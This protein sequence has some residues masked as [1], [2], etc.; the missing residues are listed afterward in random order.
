MKVTL[1]HPTAMT[2]NWKQ[3]LRDVRCFVVCAPIFISIN[4]LSLLLCSSHPIWYF[5]PVANESVVLAKYAYA[6][7]IMVF[8]R[9]QIF[10]QVCKQNQ[11]ANESS[12][13]H[14]VNQSALDIQNIMNVPALSYLPSYRSPCFHLKQSSGKVQIR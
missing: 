9:N 14:P 13:P 1:F 8:R 3:G 4:F 6:T 7:S 12:L 2:Q 5:Y 11:Y 10:P